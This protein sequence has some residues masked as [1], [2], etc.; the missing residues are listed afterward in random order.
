MAIQE[1]DLFA[2]TWAFLRE[3]GDSIAPVL[4]FLPN[5]VVGG[6]IHPFERCWAL[7]DGK[8]RF[9]NIYGQTTTEFGD[10]AEDEHGLLR[11]K[12]RSRVDPGTVHVLERAAMPS[13]RDFGQAA[14]DDVPQFRIAE[15]VGRGRRRNLVV[16]RANAHSLHTQWPAN[17]GEEDR[18]WDL[19]ISWYGRELPENLAGWEYFTHQPNDRKFSAIYKLFLEGSPLLD[20]ENIYMPDDDLMT[21]WGDINKLFNIFRLG[22]F[23]IAQP[24]LVPTSYVTHPVTAQNPD[25]VLR[26]TSFVELMCPVFT[27]AF[28]RICLPTFEASFSGFGLDHIWSQ[29]AGRVPGRIAIIDDI[30]VA[31]TRPPNKNY[32]VIAAIMEE[33]SMAGLYRS[34]KSYETFGGIGRKYTFG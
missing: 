7:A 33:R 26:Y 28:L 34:S 17:I 24:S 19:C 8:L 1:S 32:D 18:N 30:A 25:Y 4:R 6:Y 11:L 14:S 16:L 10:H 5:G 22:G 13:A 21:S 15:S 29:L 27:R 9:L 12:G 20:Y 3:N 23:D 31:H 2:G